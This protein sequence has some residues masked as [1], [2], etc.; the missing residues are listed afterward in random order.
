MKKVLTAALAVIVAALAL[1]GCS[2]NSNSNSNNSSSTNQSSGTSTDSSNSIDNSTSSNES[3]SS[4]ESNSSEDSSSSSGEE[5]NPNAVDLLEFPDTRAGKLA[6]AGLTSHKD[7]W[8]AMLNIV[9]DK[10]MLEIMLPGLSPDL[11]EDYCFIIDMVGINSHELLVAKPKAG[12]EEAL[13]SAFDA[14]FEQIKSPDRFLYP[15]GEESVA[16]AV[17]GTTDDGYLYIVVHAYGADV[18]AA[19]AAAN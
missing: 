2:D 16:G 18:A 11:C 4:E 14:R 9:D 5:S 3:T 13:K 17:S 7:E 15:A 19:M 6:K 1:T 12:S 8:S 10:D